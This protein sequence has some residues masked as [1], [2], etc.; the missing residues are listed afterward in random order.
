[1]DEEDVE[2]GYDEVWDGGEVTSHLLCWL[3]RDMPIPHHTAG[4]GPRSLWC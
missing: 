4:S 3:I 2:M 1:M